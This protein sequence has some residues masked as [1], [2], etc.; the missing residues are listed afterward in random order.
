MSALGQQETER[1]P[2][3]VTQANPLSLRSTISV[4]GSLFAL[5]SDPATK[6]RSFLPD[7]GLVW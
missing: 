2:L 7:W 5:S 6:L 3:E 1:K 4:D